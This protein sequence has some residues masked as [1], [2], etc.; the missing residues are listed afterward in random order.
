MQIS[1]RFCHFVNYGTHEQIIIL[2]V[3]VSFE[4]EGLLPSNQMTRTF[5]YIS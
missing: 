1:D 3:E 4:K 5:F 2:L